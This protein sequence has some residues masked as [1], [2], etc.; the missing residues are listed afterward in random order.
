[1]TTLTTR[2]LLA[3]TAI[4]L[5][6]LPAAAETLRYAHVGAEGDIQTRFAAEAAEAIE[7]ATDGEVSLQVFPA[8]QLGNVAEMVDGVR[9]GS[10]QMGHHDF[11]SLAR[12]VPEMAVFNAPFIYRDGAH[13]LAATDPETSPALQALN[14]ELVENGGM[15]VIGRIYR[16]ARHISS[17]FEIDEPADME[18]KPFRAVP[19][20]LWISMIKGM[21]ATPTPVE[22]SELPT[23]LMTGLVVGQENPL[24]MISANKL[25]E[26]QSHVAM[27]GHMQ[28]VLAV[29]VNDDAWQGLEEDQREAITAALD[30]KAAQ[31]LEWAQASEADLV[32]ELTEAGMTFTTA[33]TGLDL[34]SFRTGVLAQIEA[35][36]PEYGEYI[37]QIMAV[38]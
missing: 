9:M 31:S 22:V 19:L 12:I 3:A 33:E 34:E 30:E 4:A 26:V 38:E 6:A 5:C 16:G 27:T 28:S 21:G 18:G 35:D 15:R 7:A 2:R 23:A 20:D 8:S 1:M 37:E 14:A 36:F 24:T 13:A 11:A 29:F 10:I 25:Y 32:D 17:N